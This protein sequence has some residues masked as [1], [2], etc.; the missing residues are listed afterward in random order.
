MVDSTA[1]PEIVDSEVEEFEEDNVDL[2]PRFSADGD[3]MMHSVTYR[4]S[5][6]R[7]QVTRISTARGAN[8]V[9][10]CSI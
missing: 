7:C 3:E 2:D 8:F 1:A 4:M 9:I 10:T 5:F 6:K